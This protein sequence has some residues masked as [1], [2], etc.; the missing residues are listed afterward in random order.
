M[1]F[2][3]RY[4]GIGRKD[5]GPGFEEAKHVE[6]IFTVLKYIYAFCVS[7][8]MPCLRGFDL[9]GHKEKLKK[10]LKILNKYHDPIIEERI[11]QWKNG[12]KEEHEDL[13][14]VLI[15]LK[16]DNGNSLLTAEEIKA[17]T[18]VILF[19]HNFFTFACMFDSSI[20]TFAYKSCMMLVDNKILNRVDF[21]L[22]LF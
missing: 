16:D 15:T 20:Q 12:L 10:A 3:K 22:Q 19:L 18:I 6:A 8:Y 13:L 17:Q 1:I 9:D 2:N 21:D 4:F 5:G 14:D 11:Q 7:D